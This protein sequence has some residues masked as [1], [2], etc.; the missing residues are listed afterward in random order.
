VGGHAENEHSSVGQFEIS[1]PRSVDE[2]VEAVSRAGY[3]AVF[4]D[5]HPLEDSCA[6]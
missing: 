1:D 2:V 6:V 3:Q 4:K 5:W